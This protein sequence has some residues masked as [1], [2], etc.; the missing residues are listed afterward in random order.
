MA[1][2]CLIYMLTQ[3]LEQ[4]DGKSVQHWMKPEKNNNCFVVYFL[5]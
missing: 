1:K 5:P 4:M 2:T 3:T